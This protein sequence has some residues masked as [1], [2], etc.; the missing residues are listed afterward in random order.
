MN[1]AHRALSF[2]RDPRVNAR[3][4]DEPD[5]MWGLDRDHRY[6]IYAPIPSTR[7]VG[8]W[9]RIPGK[10]G[11]A[12][13]GAYVPAY[14]SRDWRTA[15]AASRRTFASRSTARPRFANGP[16]RRSMRGYGSAPA[17]RRGYGRGYARGP[18]PE[19]KNWDISY[20]YAPAAAA[21]SSNAVMQV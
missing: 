7:V 21:L 6:K 13:V 1:F 4:P 11:M 9:N 17:S 15:N 18:R 16:I 10:S 8:R 2:L 12:S 19:L 5:H 3:R 14:G 20:T